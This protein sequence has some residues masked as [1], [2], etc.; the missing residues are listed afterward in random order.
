M[1]NQTVEFDLANERVVLATMI[2]S[3]EARRQIAAEIT[4]DDFGDDKHKVIARA[5]M[6]MAKRNLAWSEDTL[7]DLAGKADF[8]GWAYLRKLVSS[9]DAN[10]NVTHHVRQLRVDSAKLELLR[11]EVPELVTACE[12]PKAP[13]ERLLKVVRAMSTRIERTDR[14]FTYAGR[15]LVESYNSTLRAR[16]AVK[17]A[18]FEPT[19]LPLLDSL[20]G[21]GLAPRKMSVVAGRPGMGKTT[22]IANVIRLRAAMGKGTF[23]CGWEMEV[24]DYFD[25]MISQETGIPA[26]NLLRKSHTLDAEDLAHVQSLLERY[27]DAALLEIQVNPFG[28]LERP[29]DRFA[30]LNERNLDFFETT[31][32]RASLTKRL[33][34]VDVVGK[35]FAKRDPDEITQGLVRIRQM[36]KDYDVHIMLLHHIG[37]AGTAAGGNAGRPSIEHLKGSGAFEEEADLIMLLDRPILR[38]NAARRRKMVD[39]MNLEIGKQR[40]GPSPLMVRYRY[41]GSRF[42]L[43]DETSVDISAL[44][45]NGSSD[46]DVE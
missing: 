10:T 35:L 14:R 43:D 20:L 19:G 33:V 22:F 8:G 13:P 7:R 15:S 42:S 18:D 28:R 11:E 27:G 25:M 39:V 38:V 16:R 46:D 2:H 32:A 36:A 12:D 5:L 37:R 17:D 1:S 41:D 21:E 23:L 9:Y 44:E 3:G 31:V 45:K 6:E 40:K 24:D 29:K 34:V 4:V 26:A 30:S